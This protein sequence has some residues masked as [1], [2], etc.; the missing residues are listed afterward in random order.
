MTLPDMASIRN[1]LSASLSQDNV[2]TFTLGNPYLKPATATQFDATLEWYFARV[3]SLTVD[4]FYK[5]VQNFFYASTVQRNFT[6]NGI[7]EPIT[8][9]IADNY[10]GHGHIKG[11]EIAYQQVFTFLPGFLKGFGVNAS[12][13]YLDSSG[14]PNS[15]LNTGSADAVSNIKPG[16]LPLEQ[17]SKHTVN[18]EGFYERGPL[19]LRVAYNWR[20]KFLLT[21]SD[22]IFPYAPIF[23][24]ATGQ[25]DGSIFLNIGKHLKIGVQGVN[26]LDEVTKTLQAYNGDPN[27]LAPRSY[28]INDRRYS[29][30]LRANF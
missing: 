3:G 19:S 26:L 24:A 13:T 11:A 27:Q 6:Q 20:S 1:S 4:L 29:F 2:I 21:A 28:F 30:I 9:R 14:L 15:F 8:V 23:N 5:D 16:N 12:Y 7:T 10:S 17:L 22:V 18:V 25:L